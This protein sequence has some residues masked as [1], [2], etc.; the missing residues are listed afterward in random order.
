MKSVIFILFS[1]LIAFPLSAQDSTK[2]Q[3]IELIPQFSGWQFRTSPTSEFQWIGFNGEHL[4]PYL[5]G[6]N[7]AAQNAFKQFQRNDIVTF[8]GSMTTTVSYGVFL[9]GITNDNFDI[10]TTSGI[11]I[12]AGTLTSWISAVNAQKKL[13][14]TIDLHNFRKS[15][16]PSNLFPKIQPSSHSLGLGLVWE[17]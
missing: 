17:L 8:I 2:A 9:Y 7:L 13:Y 11:F 6:N 15:P 14:E 12:L 1:L 10:V 3:Y 5:E 4:K 16:V